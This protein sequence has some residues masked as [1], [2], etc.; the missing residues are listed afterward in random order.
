MAKSIVELRANDF[1]ATEG[2]PVEGYLGAVIRDGKFAGIGCVKDA[3]NAIYYDTPT[4]HNYDTKNLSDEFFDRYFLTVVPA[5][6]A[7]AEVS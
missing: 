6:A 5:P 2:D 4:Q 1:N 7:V 3:L